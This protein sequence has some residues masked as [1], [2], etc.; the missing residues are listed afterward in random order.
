MAELVADFVLGRLREW[1]VHRVFGYPGDGINAFLGA[2]DRAEGDPEFIQARHEEMAAFMACGHAKYTGEVGVCIA[3]SGPGAIHLLNGLYDAKLDHAP[4]LAI[5]G[6]QKRMSLGSEYQQEVD[7]QVLFKDVSESVN[8]CMEAA[9]ARHLVDGAIRTA[10]DRKGVTT[11]IFPGDVQEEPAVASPPRMHGAVYSSVGYSRPRVIPHQGDLDRAAEILNEGKRVA[12]LVGQGALG[13]ADEVVE[14]AE[15]LGAGVAKALLGKAVLPDDLPFVTGSIGLLGTTASYELMSGCDTLF[16]I[17]T[18]FPYAEWLPKEGDARCVEIDLDGRRVGMRYPVDVQLIGDATETL[19]ELNPL[20]RRKEDRAWREE[21]EHQVAEW[22]RVV[23]DRV[24]MDA[25]PMNPQRVAW[26]LNAL[27][28][29]DA[30]L[31]ADSGSSTNWWARD[32]KIGK[33]MLASLS[34]TLATMGPATP[35]AIAAKFAFPHRPVIAFVGDGSFQMNGLA[36]LITV[37]RYWERWGDPRLV[38][39][40]FNNEDL[41]QVTWEQRALSG[42][43]KYPPTQWI[44]SVPYHQVAELFGL[45]GLY[46]DDGNAVRDAWA[47]ALSADRPCVLEVKVDP[48]VPPLPPHIRVEQAKKMAK[49]M[50]KGDPERAG[51]MEKSLLGKLMEFRESIPG[52]K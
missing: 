23:E 4:V 3:T 29:D 19:R 24:H 43:P 32:L 44:P 41:N 40:V 36:E 21:V 38:F 27:L 13:A 37:K 30:I 12:I 35:Y 28:P 15:L 46:C 25:D 33:G 49:A 45:K 26:E 16:M 22:W 31:A 10:L 20:L 18:S 2:F 52:K 1:G 8:V 14:A 6:Q 17:G 11:V 47:E 39:C 42:D 9:Q 5:V 51:V 50:V 48:E 34:G 7:L